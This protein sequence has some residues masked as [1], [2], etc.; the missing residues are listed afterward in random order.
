MAGSSG[1]LAPNRPSEV[2]KVSVIGA[3]N[4]SLIAALNCGSSVSAVLLTIRG[5]IA[6][7]PACCSTA[8][9]ASMLG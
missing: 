1:A 6:S 8:S 9:L 5:A 3:P 4:A 7:R 2:A